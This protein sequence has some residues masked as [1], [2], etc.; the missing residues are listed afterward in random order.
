MIDL[1]FKEILVLASREIREA[2]RYNSK[3]SEIVEY[4]RENYYL[5]LTSAKLSRRFRVSESYIAR[6]FKEATG[7]SPM[8]LIHKIRIDKAA[9]MIFE[10]SQTLIDIASY[11]GYKNK[12]SFTRMFK[13]FRGISPSEYKKHL[14][15]EK[16]SH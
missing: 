9:A 13:K 15:E 4:I 7:V 8:E 5:D 10:T 14:K 2:A 12:T 1:H 11:V 6:S 16:A 3:F